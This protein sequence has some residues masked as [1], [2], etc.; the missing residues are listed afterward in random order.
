MISIKTLT[1]HAEKDNIAFGENNINVSLNDDSG[2]YF[3]KLECNMTGSEL[4]IDF[5]QVDDL[6]NAIKQLQKQIQ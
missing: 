5:N 3:I 4:S 6:F 2:G 1:I